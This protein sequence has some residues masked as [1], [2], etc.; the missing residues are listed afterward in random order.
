MQEYATLDEVPP[1]LPGIELALTDYLMAGE[2]GLSFARR[3]H[4][5]HSSVPVV[6]VTAYST[7]EIEGDAAASGFISALHKPVGYERVLRLVEQLA[8]RRVP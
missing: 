1:P 4:R 8:G 3:F 7:P 2:N 5:S 6:M